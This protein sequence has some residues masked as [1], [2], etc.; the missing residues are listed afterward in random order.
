[1]LFCPKELERPIHSFPTQ[2]RFIFEVLVMFR[3]DSFRNLRIIHLVSHKI[4]FAFYTQ[5]ESTGVVFVILTMIQIVLLNDINK[6]F[7]FV[8]SYDNSYMPKR[9]ILALLRD[10][11]IPRS[12][13]LDPSVIKGSKRDILIF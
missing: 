6:A 12:G 4:V 3:H 1:M 5:F 9:K 13:N 11:K 7:G 8:S 2:K 10:Q